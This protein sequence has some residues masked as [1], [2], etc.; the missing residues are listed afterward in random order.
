M[1][2]FLLLGNNG[3]SVQD[4]PEPSRWVG[5]LVEAGFTYFEYFTDHLDPGF[6]SN[7]LRRK[8]EFVRETLRVIEKNGLE[9]VTIAT[10][11]LPYLTN[12]LSHPF[13]DMAEE[14]LRWCRGLAD[15]AEV[16]GAKYITGHYDY[17]TQQDLSRRPKLA[18][19]RLL[20]RLVLFTDYAAKKGV[21][22]VF[23]EQ[24][25]SP[26]LKPYTIEESKK[27]LRTLNRRSAIPVMLHLDCGHAAPVPE[28]DKDHTAADKDPYKWLER[29]YP[30]GDMIFLHLQ[31][32]DRAAS[33]HWAFTPER[34]RKGVIRADKVIRSILKGAPRRAFLSFEMLYPR[35]TPLELIGKEL[36][37]SREYFRTAFEKMG[38]DVSTDLIRNRQG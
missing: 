10:G 12:L 6:Y 16:F 24:M 38:F 28:S 5:P 36:R 7:V 1:T 22:A 4:N 3:F 31:Q 32:T 19:S 20:D 23:L 18:V 13:D 34:N 17:I 26:N 14:G 29:R 9:T 15:M 11:R 37:E 8:S 33:R 27:M 25:Y 30:G 35:G 2:E 21:E